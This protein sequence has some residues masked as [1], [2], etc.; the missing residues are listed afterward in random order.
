MRAYKA[1]GYVVE[2]EACDCTS[3]AEEWS[4]CEAVK[5]S[6]AINYEV[7]NSGA[8]FYD[9][10]DVN[11]VDLV[12]CPYCERKFEDMPESKQLWKC[13]DCNESFTDSD[14]AANCCR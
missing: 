9:S 14:D 2:C 8:D 5:V 3:D 7:Y 11:Y 6:N 13:G 10:S 1:K 12:E 4:G